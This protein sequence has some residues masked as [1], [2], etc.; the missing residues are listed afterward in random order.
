MARLKVGY[1]AGAT[2]LRIR[3]RALPALVMLLSATALLSACEGDNLFTGEGPSFVPRVTALAAP[4]AALGGDTIRVRVDAVAQRGISRVDISLRGAVTQDTSIKLDPPEIRVSQ[5]VALPLPTM[6]TDTLIQVTASITD[7]LGNI[8]RVQETTVV[9]F[10]PPTITNLSGPSEARPGSPLLVSM[11]AAGTKRIVDF[12]VK[13][14]GAISK[15]TT[16][17]VAS[18][19]MSAAAN[20]IVDL[21]TAVQDTFLDV[22]VFARDENGLVSQTRSL[23]VPLVFDPPTLTLTLPDTVHAGST[24]MVGVDAQGVRNIKE[25]RVQLRGGINTDLVR[26]VDPSRSQLSEVVTV[27]VPAGIMNPVINVSVFA[28]D[29]GGAVSMTETGV[30]IVPLGPPTLLD[31]RG[32]V[33][34]NAGD[35][36]LIEIDAEG[37]RP[38]SRVD[39][40]FGGPV[41]SQRS[42][43]ITPQRASISSL[44]VFE[45][46]PQDAPNSVMTVTA[47]V[48][49]AAGEASA[50]G[51][52]QVIVIQTDTSATP[53]PAPVVPPVPGAITAAGGPAG[54][55]PAAAAVRIESAALNVRSERKRRQ[56]TRR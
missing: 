25:L 55:A 4:E 31:V 38:L 42:V 8:S 14:T 35:N 17:A 41:N 23:T 46:V 36:V 20:L 26:P 56:R 51:T 43:P 24:L 37:L 21:P 28:V 27:P 22:E 1:G 53:A 12:R 13:M 10:G 2:R 16:V 39:V 3:R 32:P 52:I 7:V 40:Y 11:A 15:D 18:P 9:A 44:V 45:S 50:L 48:V 30:V 33:T 29:A 54:L 5:V 34:V 19:S 49:D 6:L 47:Q